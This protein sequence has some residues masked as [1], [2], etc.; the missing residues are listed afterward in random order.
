[1]GLDGVELII[2][3]EDEFEIS[4]SDDEV[5]K[6]ATVGNMVDLILSHL[7]RS[8]NELCPSQR[9]FYIVRRTL[10][11]KYNV[12]RNLIKPSTKLNDLF[13][14]KARYKV[15][16]ELVSSLAKK[17]TFIPSLSRPRLINNIVFIFLPLLFSL[18]LI[19]MTGI[20]GIPI[21][22]IMYIFVMIILAKFTQPFKTEFP[23]KIYVVKDLIRFVTTTN[24]KVWTKDE[25]YEKL[26]EI[27]VRVLGVKP[28]D[29]KP[30]AHW[31][32][33]LAVG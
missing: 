32:K 26:R 30:E 24:D 4:I 6:S 19:F 23:N 12:P 29:I 9:G 5:Y 33:D 25:V 31:V 13:E 15:W 20:K 17:S 7:R 21:G 27:S 8:K 14:K 10:M 1:M 28:E 2:N 18:S 16:K 11:D 22:V 3:I